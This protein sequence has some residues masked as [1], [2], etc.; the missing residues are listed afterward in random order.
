MRRLSKY[1][2]MTTSGV[3]VAASAWLS[4]ATATA[5]APTNTLRAGHALVAGQ[6]L[7]SERG[8]YRAIVQSDGNVAVYQGASRRWNTRTA[9]RGGHRLN[10]QSSDG[11]LVL[12][13]RSGRALWSAGIAGRRGARL[14]M[15]SDGNLVVYTAAGRAVWSVDSGIQVVANCSKPSFEPGGILLA[16]ADGNAYLQGLH[17]T[18]WTSSQA[19]A[20]GTAVYNDCIPNCAQGHFHRI[21]HDR[22]TVTRP[23]RGKSGQRVWSRIQED[24]TPP[25]WVKTQIL[26]T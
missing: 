24:P 1:L 2:G 26:P 16:C 23:V 12:Y 21:R 25:H 19:T 20:V 13:T 9:G 15:Q 3:M 5:A 22:I 18:T 4:T 14:V 7:V 10:L 11:N 17:W 6:Q 8:G